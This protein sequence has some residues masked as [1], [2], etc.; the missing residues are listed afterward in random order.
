LVAAFAALAVTAGH[1]PHRNASAY[2]TPTG[3]YY[4]IEDNDQSDP[5]SCGQTSPSETYCIVDTTKEISA[6]TPTDP[7]H[8]IPKR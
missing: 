2:S 3:G 7:C 5:Y 1:G 8:T 6:P 4:C